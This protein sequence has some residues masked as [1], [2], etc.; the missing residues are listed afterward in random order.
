M[1]KGVT[2]ENTNLR[3]QLKVFNSSVDI[4]RQHDYSSFSPLS[5][6][7]VSD[8]S[9][10]IYSINI[11]NEDGVPVCIKRS[12]VDAQNLISRCWEEMKYQDAEM[13]NTITAYFNQCLEIEG[14]LSSLASHHEFKDSNNLKGL[15]SIHTKQLYDER[16]RLF[17]ACNMF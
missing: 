16:V 3:K 9:S 12:A 2:K 11:P 7:D 1:C 8:V 15:Y 6:E 14:R 5:W 4:L 13:S 17:G 10:A